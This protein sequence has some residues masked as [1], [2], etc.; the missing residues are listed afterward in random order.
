MFWDVG[1][2]TVLVGIW[3]WDG[4]AVGLSVTVR[5]NA[6]QL[7]M[8][9]GSEYV[10]IS[11]VLVLVH[12]WLARVKLLGRIS[13]LSLCCM[14]TDAAVCDPPCINID[15]A[16]SASHGVY[17][18]NNSLLNLPHRT[19]LFGDYLKGVSLAAKVNL[20]KITYSN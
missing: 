20:D 3:H 17:Y 7:L 16:L 11:Q 2:L 9:C 13:A 18:C 6:C 15:S 10:S 19:P 8:P 12:C 5:Q 4:D 1:L 14:H